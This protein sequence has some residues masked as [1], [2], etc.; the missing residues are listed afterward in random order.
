[1][2]S[3][4]WFSHFQAEHLF[5]DETIIEIYELLDNFCEFI[6]VHLS[7]I[8]RHK[9]AI[10]L[11]PLFDPPVMFS[12]TIHQY[13]LEICGL[14]DCPNDI[15]EAVSSLIFASARCGDL[16]ELRSIRKLFGERY[17]HRFEM[18]AVELLPGNLVNL[19]VFMDYG[20]VISIYQHG[21]FFSAFN[22]KLSL[23]VKEKLSIKSVPDD[24]KQKVLAEIAR[25][26][27]LKPEI[28]SLEYTSEL[29]Q[30]VLLDTLP[31]L[32]NSRRLLI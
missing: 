30:Q 20:F 21:F 24:V 7:Y 17:G 9:Y 4:L 6:L 2:N 28:F 18:T 11:C 12:K 14:R 1:M 10:L 13:F 19:Q 16:P 23:Q 32:P 26:Y 3:L 29:L 27:C 8:R 5:R 15:N 25:D 22:N 31:I